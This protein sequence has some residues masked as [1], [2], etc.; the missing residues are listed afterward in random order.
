MRA[1]APNCA[2]VR[3]TSQNAGRRVVRVVVLAC[4]ATLPLH[5]LAVTAAAPPGE[6]IE[7]YDDGKPKAKYRNN[8]DG[9]RNGAYEEYFPDG[10]VKVRG[11]YTAGK[12]SG[13]WTTLGEAG[14]TLEVASYRADVLDGPW[15]YHFEDTGKLRVKAKYRAGL[16]NGPVAV[17]DAKGR[18]VMQPTYPR[19]LADVEKAWAKWWPA[20]PAAP[21]F[22]QEP[23]LSPPYKAGALSAETVEEG[24]KAVKLFRFLSGVPWDPVKAD[25]GRND[26]AQ[27]GA[28][29]MHKLGRIT[30]TPEQPDD[31]DDA[32][33]KVAYAG[34]NQSNIF[35]GVPTLVA[36]VHGW[37][38]DSD[39]S[40]I[41]KV[42]HR[43][44]ILSPGLQEIGFGYA[45]GFC[46]MHVVGGGG[47]APDFNYVAFPGEGYY[48][49][50]LIGP[51]FAWSVHLNN[52]KAKVG[53]KASVE[54]TITR[55]DERFLPI[56]DPQEGEV[57]SI[58]EGIGANWTVIVFRPKPAV[59]E[60]GRY[61]VDVKGVRSPKGAPAPFG[62]FVELIEM[63]PPGTTAPDEPA[64]DGD[65]PAAAKEPKRRKS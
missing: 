27:H 25:A 22:S 23:A 30:H 41:E 58:A 20:A 4:I 16:L 47:A 38:D 43:Q 56:G 1:W 24:V 61:W 64:E 32:F 12:K 21:K 51:S 48:P 11:T 39:P 26:T 35:Q 36:A 57:A 33:F 6:V 55:L 40:N 62:Y 10:K 52:A 46:A 9:L 53:E 19:T 49:R 15:T 60:A 29:V 31:M 3:A 28:V 63:P 13:K 65:K 18:T 2:D 59:I 7:K 45:D 44:W 34:C 8:A 37:M 5:V 42:G 14:K 17:L 54:V 50:Q